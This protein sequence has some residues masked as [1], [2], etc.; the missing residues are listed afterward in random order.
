M[1]GVAAEVEMNHQVKSGVAKQIGRTGRTARCSFL[2]VFGSGL[3]ADDRAIGFDSVIQ[4]SVGQSKK[5]IVDLG[6]MN[7]LFEISL[8][9]E[10]QVVEYRGVCCRR[11]FLT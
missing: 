10:S 7:E 3:E 6:K 1:G 9:E 2:E 4:V 8:F 11:S 5:P